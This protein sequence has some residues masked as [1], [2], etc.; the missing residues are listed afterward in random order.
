MAAT[1]TGGRQMSHRQQLAK[2]SRCRAVDRFQL[3]L[4]DL[5]R[6]LCC[7]HRKNQQTSR[8]CAVYFQ[9]LFMLNPLSNFCTV[10]L[11]VAFEG[12][13]LLLLQDPLKQ[14]KD[15][16]QLKHQLEEI[17]R[18]VESEV[19]VGIPQVACLKVSLINSTFLVRPPTWTV[20]NMFALVNVVIKANA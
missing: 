10:K 15:L 14:L 1:A 2:P 5:F 8:E 3:H 13:L 12:E 20:S 6:K 16:T 17:Q 7:H 18:R 9:P 19:S 11:S 4:I